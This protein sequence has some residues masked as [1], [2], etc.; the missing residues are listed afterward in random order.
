MEE[1]GKTEVLEIKGDLEK[2]LREERRHLIYSF[3]TSI[4]AKKCFLNLCKLFQDFSS[5]ASFV[6]DFN[7]IG[8]MVNISQDPKVI[9]HGRGNIIERKPE[10]SLKKFIS[11]KYLISIDNL[12]GIEPKKRIKNIA[13]EFFSNEEGTFKYFLA[14]GLLSHKNHKGAERGPPTIVLKVRKDEEKE[15]EE[16]LSYAELIIRYSY[17]DTM[18]FLGTPL[19]R[20]E[21]IHLE[22][23]KIDKEKGVL[24]RL[25][26]NH[27]GLRSDTRHAS[28]KREKLVSQEPNM[29]SCKYAKMV[30]FI[31]SVE[32]RRYNLMPIFRKIG[33]L[34]TRK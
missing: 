2:G 1:N 3:E 19:G 31:D 21:A 25:F 9:Q 10:D 30:S 17:I 6:A 11:N 23:N 16:D 28:K 34:Y 18:Y 8:G 20:G 7:T 32:K 26:L 13:N 22:Y 24:D 5:N 15:K 29:L 33:V 14:K 27:G 4:K 12:F